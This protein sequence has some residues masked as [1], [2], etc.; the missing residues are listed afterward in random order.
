[1]VSEKVVTRFQ[2]GMPVKVFE[3]HGRN[4]ALDIMVGCLAMPDLL[5]PELCE[6][7]G[8]IGK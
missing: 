3:E 7:G 8:A 5:R 4:E 6:T 2:F 1:M